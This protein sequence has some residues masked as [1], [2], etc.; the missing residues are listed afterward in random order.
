MTEQITLEKALE[1]VS[2]TKD[3]AGKW[4]IGNIYGNV[5]GNIYGH[6]EGDVCGNVGGNVGGGVGGNV[7]GYVRGTIL[8][9]KW[10]FIETPR[11]KLARLIKEK[12][13]QE[14]IEAFNQ[15]EDSDD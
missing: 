9:K 14:L 1:L 13:D 15:L 8:G 5:L 6:V 3:R 11:E 4:F 7:C 10:A 2:F 12:G